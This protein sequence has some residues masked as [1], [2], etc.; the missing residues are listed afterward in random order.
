MTR[1]SRVGGWCGNV[2][3]A[4]LYKTTEPKVE[5]KCWTS[6]KQLID[7]D[8]HFVHGQSRAFSYYLAKKWAVLACLFLYRWKQVFC[9]KNNPRP[10]IQQF[11]P[12]STIF[13]LHVLPIV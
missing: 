12:T 10:T 7:E 1:I 8:G 9:K 4:D 13:V 6:S 3:L 2:S 5:K 11:E